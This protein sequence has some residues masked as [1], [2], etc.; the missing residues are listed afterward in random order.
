M[1][2]QSITT[3]HQTTEV[4]LWQMEE[5][6]ALSESSGE[7]PPEWVEIYEKRYPRKNS[8]DL[9][10]PEAITE[11]GLSDLLDLRHST[12]APSP[13]WLPAIKLS[14]LLAAALGQQ[15]DHEERAWSRRH[16]PSAG[17][18]FTSEVYVIASRVNGIEPGAYHYD[19]AAHSLEL[20]RAGEPISALRRCFG[21]KW[22]S[23]SRA[24]IVITSV[25]TRN[26][27]KYGLRGYRY[28]LLEAGHIGQ[29]LLLASSALGL[30]SSPVGGFADTGLSQYLD[31]G[32]TFEFPVYSCVLD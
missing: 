25:Q 21:Q 20:I 22:I 4:Q 13:E 8:T 14:S 16:Y 30:P 17:A 5:I 10:L 26:V 24:V 18:R 3:F 6:E 15:V 28:S 31:L 1:D 7:W 9:P 11:P 2:R 29:N 27:S 23:Q 32:D 12:R 19:F